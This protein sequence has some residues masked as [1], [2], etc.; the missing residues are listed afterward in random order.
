[1][2]NVTLSV[3]WHYDLRWLIYAIAA[4]TTHLQSVDWRW[5]RGIFLHLMAMIASIM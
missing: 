3:G 1:M 5:A 4:F 2:D